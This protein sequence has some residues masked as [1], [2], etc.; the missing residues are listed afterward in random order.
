MTVDSPEF[1][2]DEINSMS[3]V[4]VNA[5]PDSENGE[6]EIR[7]THIDTD[8]QMVFDVETAQFILYL[9]ESGHEQGIADVRSLVK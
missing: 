6:V 5:M 8:E 1:I 4:G 9:I 3:G 2:A 7:Y